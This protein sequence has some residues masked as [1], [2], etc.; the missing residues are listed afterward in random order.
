MA[1]DNYK[2]ILKELTDLKNRCINAEK[3]CTTFL[4]RTAVDIKLASLQDMHTDLG[5]EIYSELRKQEKQLLHVKFN[6]KQFKNELQHLKPTPQFVETLRNVME[7]VESAITNA[8]Q[9][10][11]QIQESLNEEENVLSLEIEAIEKRVDSWRQYLGHASEG[12]AISSHPQR[13]P[14]MRQESQANK[15]AEVEQFDIYA[16]QHGGLYGGWDEQDHRLFVHLF[17]RLKDK[18]KLA[19]EMIRHIPCFTTE[20]L[21][22]HISWYETFL[23][24]QESKK[25]AIASWRKQKQIE[26]R[27]EIDVVQEKTEAPV[28]K[29]MA[30]KEQE[31]R[32]KTK[33][34]EEWKAKCKEIDEEQKH[35]KCIEDDKKMH[36]QEKERDRQRRLKALALQYK[37]K[38]QEN[39]EWQRRL[40][41]EEQHLVNTRQ[42]LAAEEIA[43]FRERDQ[44]LHQKRIEQEKLKQRAVQQK[45]DRLAKLK[46]KVAVTIEKDPTRLYQPT[47]GWVERTK[48]V[49][50]S[51]DAKPMSL[52]HRA[53][54]SW[55]HGV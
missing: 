54:P 14:A 17:N 55:R 29:D 25:L 33:K 12:G 21:Q 53:I 48:R 19:Q 6:I 31:R 4:Q 18:D 41:H 23:Q 46:Q 40:E 26:N 45:E 11:R 38:K 3:E 8:K 10:Q 28:A 42:I 1:N 36:A 52:P 30:K 15:P 24:L 20:E 37:T 7:E 13:Q 44:K 35:Q 49:G 22:Q 27:Q 32:E 50:P 51:G 47:K 39:E 5:Q 2:Q 34:I 9:Q 16:Q 43:R